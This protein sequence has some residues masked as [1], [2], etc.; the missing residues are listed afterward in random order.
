MESTVL[1]LK[2]P[3]MRGDQVKNVQLALIK[4]G[5]IINAD[6]IYGNDTAEAVC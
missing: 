3:M 5:Y 2:T 1:Q 4:A 6:G